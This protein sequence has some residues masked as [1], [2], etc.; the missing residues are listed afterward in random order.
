MFERGIRQPGLL[1]LAAY[2]RLANLY[3]EALIYDGID[4]PRRLPAQVKSEGIKAT[5]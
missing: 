2:A 5:R 3:V 1:V 4:L